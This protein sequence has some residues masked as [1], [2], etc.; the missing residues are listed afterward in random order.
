MS[1]NLP[2][3]ILKSFNAANIRT[4]M[5][6]CDFISVICSKNRSN[7]LLEKTDNK[8]NENG[9]DDLHFLTFWMFYFQLL[10]DRLKS[11]NDESHWRSQFRVRLWL[12]FFKCTIPG[13]FFAWFWSFQTIL[14]NINRTLQRELDLNSD[15]QSRRRVRWPLDHH[16]HGPTMIMVCDW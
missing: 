5:V 6:K 2:V 4:R 8:R 12:W 10:N 13:H 9:D 16:Y 1:S 15:R 11:G 3:F 14:Q 7:C